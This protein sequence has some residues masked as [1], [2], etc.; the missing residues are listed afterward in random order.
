MNTPIIDE[1]RKF[2]HAMETVAPMLGRH[3]YAIELPPRLFERFWVEVM[4]MGMTW[5]PPYERDAK[6]ED[7]TCIT[8]AYNNG[9]CYVRRGPKPVKE[10]S[11]ESDGA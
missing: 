5:I 11:D 7:V 3:D 4:C 6:F 8:M 10:M 1:I 9:F 2:V